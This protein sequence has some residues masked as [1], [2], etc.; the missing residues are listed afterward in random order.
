MPQNMQKKKRDRTRRNKYISN[1]GRLK[2]NPIV[3][4]FQYVEVNIR[5]V[6]TSPPIRN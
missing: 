4:S 6:L 2:H 5:V 1:A 3:F